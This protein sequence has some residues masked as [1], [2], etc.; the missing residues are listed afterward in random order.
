MKEFDYYMEE[1]A[2]IWYRTFFTIEA[3]TEDE[4]RQKAK[5]FVLRGDHHEHSWH[6]M[7]DTLELLPVHQNCDQPTAELR[8][9]TTGDIIWDNG[10]SHNE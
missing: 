9:Q 6:E 7:E 5:K 2:S 10:G 4:A 8:E 3:E 1:K